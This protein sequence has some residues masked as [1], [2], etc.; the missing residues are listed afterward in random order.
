VKRLQE[1]FAGNWAIAPKDYEA[2][3]A[4]LMPCI[5]RGNLD[6]A[7]AQLNKYG[8]NIYAAFPTNI[9]NRWELDDDTLPENSVAVIVLEGV[10]LSWETYRLERMIQEVEENPKICGAVLWINGP[11][12]MVAHVD[13]V[14]SMLKAMTK[15][16][17][18]FVAGTMASAHFWLGTSVDRTFIASPLCEV[19]S[20][21]VMVT[22][23]SFKEY[24]KKNG[25]EVRDIYPDTADLKNHE[26]RALEEGDEGPIKEHLEALHKAF[27]NA[28]ASNL[29]IDY[30]PELPLF[31]GQ[32]FTGDE[33][34]K[35]GYIDQ[36]GTLQD[37]VAWVLGR[38]TAL[39]IDKLSV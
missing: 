19:G 30:D 23:A 17:A 24:F 7:E 8:V 37:A 14:A 35:L 33:A 36:M 16:V 10:L 34:V 12:G 18:T 22:W 2:F 6:Q 13:V 38:S 3:C 27:A 29:G 26:T 25:I 11:G 28:V 31:R 39:E 9:A 32:I 5:I 15:P 4:L 20:V 21:G 1:I